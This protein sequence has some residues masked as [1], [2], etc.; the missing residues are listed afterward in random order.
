MQLTDAATKAPGRGF[1]AI[2]ASVTALGLIVRLPGAGSELWADEVYAVMES[3]RTPFPQTLAIFPGDNKHPLYALLAHVALSV[4][5]ETPWAVRLP[6]ILFGVATIPLLYALGR[7]ITSRMEALAS[8]ALLALSYHH[9]WFSQNARGYSMLAFFAVLTTL[10][11][12]RASESNRIQPWIWYGIAAGLGAYTHLTFVFAVVAQFL[13]VALA[14]FGWPRRER[15]LGWRAPIA[16]FAL[17]AAVTLALYLPMLSQVVAFFLHK[18]SNLL[19]ISSPGWALGEAIRVLRVGFGGMF[20]IGVAVVAAGAA[21]GVVGVLSYARQS[22]RTA[23]LLC[24]PAGV[25]LLGALTARGTMYPRFF[26]M[27]AGLALLCGMR[28]VFATAAWAARRMHWSEGVGQ[29]MGAG[30]AAL[31]ILLS[32][33]SIPLNWRLPKQDFLG[34]M[35]YVEGAAAAGDVIAVTDVTASVYGPYYRKPWARVSSVSALEILRR[36]LADSSAAA[37]TGIVWLLYTFPRYIEK[38]DAPLAAYVRRECTA[39][40]VRTFPG[41]VGGGDISVCR[42]TRT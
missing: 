7:R 40:N 2:V 32:A 31:V 29:R 41:T 5:G 27:L 37:G 9:V 34:A 14:I 19:G 30:L 6:A 12:L 25:T 38:L 10:L 22:M 16:G 36:P 18:Q 4:F 28:G 15:R 23:L 26:F 17:S 39:D 42:L 21:I 33:L 35:T 20:G 13:V 3:F 8:T 11:L 1:W 24:L